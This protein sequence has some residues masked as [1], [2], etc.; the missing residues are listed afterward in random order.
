MP[1]VADV[2]RR[3]GHEYLDRFGQD[4]L[5]SHRRA[6]GD[7]LACRTEALGGQLLQCD[8]CGQ[9]H[10][11]YHSC[12]NRSCPKCHRLE[13]EAWLAARRQELLP[14]SYFHVVSTVPQELR[15][16]IRR[17]QQDLYDILL[18]AAAQ[19]LLKLAADPHYV[20]GL[21]GVLCVL[22]TWSRTLAYHPHVHCLVPAGGVSADRTQWQ[23]ARRSYLVPVHALAPLFR[24]V[25]RALVRQERPDL[26]IPESV[27]TTE[28]VVYC[29][30][31]LQGPERVLNYLGRYVHRIALTNSRLLAIEAGHVCFRYQ[32][33]QD[34]RWKTMT[35][36]ALEFIR[37]FLQH[38]LP[39]GFHKVRYDGLWSPIHRPLLHHLQRW[40]AGHVPAPPPT[41]PPRESPSASWAPP[42]RAGQPCPSCAQ[43]LLVVIRSLPR[44]P[45]GPPCATAPAAGFI[46]AGSSRPQLLRAGAP[47]HRSVHL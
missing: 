42:L 12:R 29:K 37:R 25:F 45:R 15:E 19:A 33:V 47:W 23:P 38:V 39:Q 10:H 6:I 8:R 1:E 43:G 22:H 7:L 41:A 17:H 18:R 31:A 2:F 16:I 27:W 44:P 3:Y 14:V 30:P 5:P 4:L 34:Q 35:L 21:I 13:T 46:P 36:P 28:W 20:G 24:G 40:L 11:V 26:T 9:E 32:D